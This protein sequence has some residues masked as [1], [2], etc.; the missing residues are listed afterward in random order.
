MYATILVP[1]DGS[2]FGELALPVAARLA[3]AHGA[4]LH[5]AAVHGPGPMLLPLV[6][7]DAPMLDAAADRTR[8]DEMQAYLERTADRLRE[9]G[10]RVTVGLLAGEPVGVAVADEAAARGAGLIVLTTHGRGGLSRVWLGSVTTDLLRHARTPLLVVRAHEP[11]DRGADAGEPTT[12]AAWRGPRHVLVPVDGSAFAL[13]AVDVART[14]GEPFGARL[15]LLRVVPTAAAFLPYDATFWTAAEA[16][17]IETQRTLALR[18]TEDAVARLRGDGLTADGLVVV[19]PDPAR[20][21]LHAAAEQRVDTV[22]MST[23]A[24]GGAARLLLGSV[25]D[26]VI[27]ASELPVLVVRPT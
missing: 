19:A 5:L 15:T 1:L 3:E 8:R 25:T 20:A 27:R 17:A 23:H 26:K 11:H 2:P 9:A 22:A 18:E 10:H 12:A 7:E 21:I 14:L 4:A 16:E 13:R 6:T 24:R